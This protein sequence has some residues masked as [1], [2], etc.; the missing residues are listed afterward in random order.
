VSDGLINQSVR[1]DAE[2]F[3]FPEH[4]LKTAHITLYFPFLNEEL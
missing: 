2:K 4:A 3:L 1:R